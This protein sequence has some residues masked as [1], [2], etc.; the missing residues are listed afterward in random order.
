MKLHIK[1]LVIAILSATSLMAQ[2][3]QTIPS[4]PAVANGVFPNGLSYYVV[5]NPA[6]KGVVDFAL[7]QKAGRKTNP[8]ISEEDAVTM[9]REA[10]TS[11]YR[12]LSPSVQDYFVRLGVV[13]QKKGFVEVTDNATTFRFENVVLGQNEQVLDSTLLVLI[14]MAEK[15]AMKSKGWFSPSDQAIIV[16]GDIDRNKVIQKL[17]LLSYILPSSES[18]P[19][20]GYV[21]VEQDSLQVVTSDDN[22]RNAST[23]SAV[24]RLQRTPHEYMNT[25]Q[26]V[27]YERFM[28]EL[29]II[30]G[31]RLRAVLEASEV[32]V[33]DVSYDYVNS[34]ASLG[35]ENF[36]VKVT[37]APEH[38]EEAT[39]ALASVMSGLDA[40]DVEIS[41]L[42]RAGLIFMEDVNAGLNARESNSSYIDRC[43]AAFM[44]NSSLSSG[45][46]IVSFHAS[47]NLSDDVHLKIFNSIVS[48]S[49]DDNR[50][51]TLECVG[52]DL[53]QERIAEVF[54]K[55]WNSGHKVVRDSIKAVQPLALYPAPAVPVKVRSFRK[56]HMSGGEIWRLTNG[57]RIMIMQMPSDRVYYSLALNRGYADVPDLKAGEG[58]YFSEILSLSRIGGV[59]A[60]RFM[61]ELRRRKITMDMKAGISTLTVKGSAP[62]HA[63]EDVVRALL[64][65]MYDREIDNDRLDYFIR[66]EVLKQEYLKDGI[67]ERISAVDSRM[68]PDYKYTS[69]KD[70]GSLDAG[71]AAKV[72][73]YMRAQSE[74]MNDGM[75]ILVGDVDE[76][77][78][79]SV[80]QLYG[81]AFKTQQRPLARPVIKY[82]PIS[83]TVMCTVEGDV[84]NIDIAMSTPMALT[85]DNYY[86]AAM[87]SIALRKKLSPVVSDAGM[88]LRLKYD[89]RKYPHERFSVMVSLGESSVEGY[90]PNTVQTD[91][92]LAL[93][94]VRDALEDPNSLNITDDDLASWKEILKQ[95]VSDQKKTPEYWMNAISMRY[96]DGKD[97]TTGCDA[98]IDAVT[99]DDIRNLLT[100][101]AEGSR[102]EY[103]IER[104]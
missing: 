14:G 32:P 54:G 16:A 34:V 38:L 89:C 67:E 59:S 19:R 44:Y 12:L 51:L 57:F 94:A 96:L 74:K 26:P 72:D 40:G 21:W 30:A 69:C 101:L 65:V 33:A 71:F 22:T 45:K 86:T 28:R 6:Y 15:A 64:T 88:W 3:I 13:P 35:D 53:S 73:S 39:S 78:L 41:E 63:L 77:M 27:I 102:V 91:P 68:C 18:L 66:N 76:K 98:K 49:L 103:I 36:L 4:D 20:G 29:G 9:S 81:G 25:V 7:V 104:K 80:L 17:K 31:N 70:P 42:R 97:F 43:I 84:D 50:N 23:V 61:D 10:L 46:E 11:Q 95:Y 92:M 87:A 85:S 99:A 100:S 62:D 58:A 37:V 75:L 82:Q 5:S 47:R 55:A 24:W 56:E 2:T 90:A 52:G 60:E 48:A 8:E 1:L 79:K 83:G 93:K